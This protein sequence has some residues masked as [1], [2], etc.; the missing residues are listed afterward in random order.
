M[1]QQLLDCR[2]CKKKT[3]HTIIDEFDLPPEK[4]CV[5]CVS[6][7]ARG[8]ALLEDMEPIDD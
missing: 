7:T 2:I 8:I 3:R 5:Q 1:Q 4:R 6:C